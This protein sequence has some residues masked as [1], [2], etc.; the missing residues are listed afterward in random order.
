M[1]EIF[2]LLDPGLSDAV[3]KSAHKNSFNCDD[4][5]KIKIRE[6]IQLLAAENSTSQLVQEIFEQPENMPFVPSPA[7]LRKLICKAA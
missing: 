1:N 2:P 6:A 7:V 5:S 3:A 4:L